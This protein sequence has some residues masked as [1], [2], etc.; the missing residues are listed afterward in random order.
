MFDLFPDY[1]ADLKNEIAIGIRG[2]ITNTYSYDPNLKQAQKYVPYN[3][4]F[5]NNF[6]FGELLHGGGAVISTGWISGRVEDKAKDYGALRDYLSKGTVSKST[7]SIGSN[8]K[9]DSKL[10]YDKIKQAILEPW[11][12]KDSY[13]FQN[14]ILVCTQLTIKTGLFMSSLFIFN[15]SLATDVAKMLKDTPLANRLVSRV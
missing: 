11:R 13:L 15:S 9:V 10:G 6:F 1:S 8:S 4:I 14:P 7:M 3:L 2:R 12:P 5:T